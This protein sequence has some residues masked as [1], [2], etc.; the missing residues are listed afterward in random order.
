VKRSLTFVL[1]GIFSL[2]IVYPVLP[3]SAAAAEEQNPWTHTLY[4]EN[5]LFN[6]TDSNY[7]NGVK[8]SIISPDLSPHAPDG[9]LPRRAMEFI[10][11]IPFISKSTP[12]FKHKV[13]FSFG[14]NM[15]TP[16][17]I[18][19]SD[20]IEDDR[21][22]A[23]WTYISTSYHRINEAE[24]GMRFMDTVELQLGLVGP[25]SYAEETQKLVHKLRD[26]QTPNGWDHQLNNEPGLV[27][28]FERKWLFKPVDTDGAGYSVLS[29]MGGTIG[30]IYTYL[31]TGAE[32]R[33]GWNIPEDFGVS[34]IRPAGSTRL[35]VGRKFSTFLFG[36]VNMRAVARDIFLDGNTFSESHS[37]DKNYFVYDVA[38]GL[39]VSYRNVMLTWTEVRRSKEFKGQEKGHSFGSIAVSYSFPF[40]LRD[41]F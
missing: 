8:Y 9:K 3:R 27:I 20:L 35:E 37:V 41:M 1:A 39:A 25:Q 34:L 10:H 13:E 29:H 33:F 12:Q 5:D 26:L 19:R 16:A 21:P 17:D 28:A 15:Y 7:T 2:L 38:G 23:G 30:N 22:Y 24:D 40:D 36:A 32:L 18:S 14:Q 6:G 4:F 31:N 11:K